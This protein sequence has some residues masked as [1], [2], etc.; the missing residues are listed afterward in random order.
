MAAY[1][2]ACFEEAEGDAAFIAK[3]L[4]DIARAK[5]M[6]Q[7]ARDGGVSRES[8]YKALSGER[9]PGFDT[10]LKGHGC[11]GSEAARRSGE[12]SKHCPTKRSNRCSCLARTVELCRSGP[13]IREVTM[14]TW[15]Y[16]VLR[17][18][19]K[20][21]EV[22][23]QIH[24]VFYDETGRINGWTKDPVQPSGEILSELRE[25]I[26]YFLSAFRKDVLEEVNAEGTTLLRP[27]CQDQHVNDGHY[28]EAMDRASVALDHCVEFVGSHPVI[29]KH[30]T[31]RACFEKAEQALNELYQ[32]AAKL[33]FEK[34]EG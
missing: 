34:D 7:V 18:E 15:N 5:G 1:L 13:P 22:T 6:S 2:E 10:I 16:R 3:A 32:E 24:E 12:Y 19:H 25:D 4:V 21:G 20:S 29:R 9:T 27:T 33:E 17:K 23:F 11:A 26:R 8:L 14:S 31:L 30:A 28:F